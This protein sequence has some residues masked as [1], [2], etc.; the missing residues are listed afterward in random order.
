MKIA[1]ASATEASDRIAFAARIEAQAREDGALDRGGP[2][3]AFRM[4]TDL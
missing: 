1:A 4:L 3:E 2:G